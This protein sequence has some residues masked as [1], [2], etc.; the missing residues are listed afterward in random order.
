M[1]SANSQPNP[2][3]PPIPVEALNAE[4]E[5]LKV[6]LQAN[7]EAIDNFLHEYAAYVMMP[8]AMM[9][10]SARIAAAA[11]VL[12]VESQKIIMEQYEQE[13]T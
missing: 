3:I 11:S 6:Q 8:C 9:L 4:L 1:V 7:V 5:K 2:Q 12:E 13:G 10:N